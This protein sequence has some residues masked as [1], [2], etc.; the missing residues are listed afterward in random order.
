MKTTAEKA[1]QT[2][3]ALFGPD[4]LCAESV[5]LAIARVRGVDSELVPGVASGFCSGVARTCDICGAVSGGILALGLC[6]GRS[7]PGEPLDDLYALVR[8]LKRRFQQAHG[9]SNC[10]E[11]LGLD[12]S[13]ESG[14]KAYREQDLYATCRAY[15]AD[16]C[17][18]VA[19]LLE[20][21]ERRSLG[22]SAG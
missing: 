11:L 5:L 15:V 18:I 19:E 7:T 12:L 22:Q 1:A 4:Y 20:D 3:A 2:G 16:A 17:R 8:E 9:A 21:Y 14:K 10:R 13:T 6:Y